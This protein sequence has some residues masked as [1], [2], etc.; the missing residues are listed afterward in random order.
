ML[1]RFLNMEIWVYNLYLQSSRTSK[2]IGIIKGAEESWSILESHLCSFL[3]VIRI[4]INVLKISEY[5]SYKE[6]RL[7]LLTVS[8]LPVSVSLDLLLWAHDNTVNH[9]RSTW[10]MILAHLMLDDNQ[11]KK[12]MIPKIPPTVPNL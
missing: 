6:E 7:V 10:Q 3:F 12:R 11:C 9:G 5:L 8:E 2:Q 4:F 1:A